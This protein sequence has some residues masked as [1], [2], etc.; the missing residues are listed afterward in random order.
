MQEKVIQIPFNYNLLVSKQKTLWVLAF[1]KG[2]K[3]YYI[4]TAISIVVLIIG[5]FVDRKGGIPFLTLLG[6][7]LLIYIIVKWYNVY[8]NWKTH[9][10]NLK[11]Y[12]YKHEKESLDQTFIFS[13]DALQYQDINRLI[14]LNWIVFN[15]IETFN[16]IIILTVKETE[17]TFTFSKQE[18]GNETYLEIEAILK[19]KIDKS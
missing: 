3:G 12:P 19:E 11:T 5:W 14:R 18:L 17:T 8:H 2:A 9:F 15:P 10:N 7:G 16:D 6:I 1:K 13:D 4:Y